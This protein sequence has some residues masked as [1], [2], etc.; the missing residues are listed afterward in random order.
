MYSKFFVLN[1]K[2]VAQS[3]GTEEI[4]SRASLKW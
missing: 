1:T 3:Q 2:C 4:N